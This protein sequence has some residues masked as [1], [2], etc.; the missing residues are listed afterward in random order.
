MGRGKMRHY[1]HRRGF[2]GRVSARTKENE[3]V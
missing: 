1:I 3:Q 2:P